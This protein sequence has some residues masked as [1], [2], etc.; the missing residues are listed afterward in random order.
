MRFLMILTQVEKEWEHAPGGE[1][2]RVIQGYQEVERDLR[3]QNKLLDSIRLRP[4][5]EAMTVRNLP[6]GRRSSES[7]PFAGTTEAIGGMYVLEC[8]SMT[9]AMQ[10]A[11]RM[12]NYG[13]GS[14][15]IRPSWP[16]DGEG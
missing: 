13:H 8:E 10:W 1:S 2:E 15:E 5:A 3:A 12:P 6:N 9:E 11:E 7:G 4:A 16:L 14:I